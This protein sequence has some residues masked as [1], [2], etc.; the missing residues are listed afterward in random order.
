MF[1]LPKDNHSVYKKREKFNFIIHRHI[2]I[3]RHYSEYI[4]IWKPWIWTYIVA[5]VSTK[6]I[7][8]FCFDGICRKKHQ[9]IEAMLARKISSEIFRFIAMLRLL[10]PCISIGFSHKAERMYPL[11]SLLYTCYILYI[12]TTTHA[13]NERNN[14]TSIPFI[15][16]Y[17]NICILVCA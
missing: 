4:R 5:V 15:R 16:I 8:C 1:A 13:N 2:Y 12:R 11:E 9:A 17:E 3:Y 10:E 7:Q 6:I 14:S